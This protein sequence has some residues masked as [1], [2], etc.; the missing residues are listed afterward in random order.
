M[1][2]FLKIF[3][4]SVRQI[5]FV[6]NR[7]LSVMHNSSDLIGVFD[8][9]TSCCFCVA[10]ENPVCNRIVLLMMDVYRLAVQVSYF[11]NTW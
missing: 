5:T 11:V 1:Q 8:N 7:I 4:A 3:L 6:D 9:V 10:V 2:N